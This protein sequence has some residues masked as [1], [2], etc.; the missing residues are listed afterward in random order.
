MQIHISSD[1]TPIYQQIVDQI[2]FRIVSGVLNAGDELPTIRGLAET[3][4]VNPNTVARAYREL[5]HEG[6]VEKRRTTGTFVSEAV[7]QQTMAQR[8]RL[9][10]PHLDKLLILSR[11][12]GLDLDELIVQLRKQDAKLSRSENQS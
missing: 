5:E 8:R 11:Q 2:R 6:L 4:C 1:S 3:L 12:L 9:I 7:S 10:A